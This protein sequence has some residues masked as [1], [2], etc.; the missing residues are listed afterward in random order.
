MEHGVAE[1]EGLDESAGKHD[2]AAGIERHAASPARP[3]AVPPRRVPVG[4]ERD[5]CTWWAYRPDRAA[6][7]AHPEE[8]ARKHGTDYARE[9]GPAGRTGLERDG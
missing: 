1:G 4:G 2:A 6:H 9:A 7:L 5:D 8:I 3:G